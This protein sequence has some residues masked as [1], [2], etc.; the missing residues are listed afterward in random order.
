MWN[1]VTEKSWSFLSP[2][3]LLRDKGVRTGEYKLFIDTSEDPATEAAENGIYNED[4]AVAIVDEVE[5]NKL[6]FKHWSCR[7]ALSRWII[8]TTS[9]T[10]IW[11]LSTGLAAVSDVVAAPEEGILATELVDPGVKTTDPSSLRWQA[12]CAAKLNWLD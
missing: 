12:R 2:P 1:G 8:A 9:T 4:M 11:A 3:G 7:E 10:S 6:A 5:D